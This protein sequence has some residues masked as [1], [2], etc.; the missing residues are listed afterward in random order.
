MKLHLF[1]IFVKR[2]ANDIQIDTQIRQ[3][4]YYG[5][6]VFITERE[7]GMQKKKIRKE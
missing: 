6:H 5:P 2:N 3:Q 1:I 7:I 4:L